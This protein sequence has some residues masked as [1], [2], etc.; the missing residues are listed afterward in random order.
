LWR[1]KFRAAEIL[2]VCGGGAV[3]TSGEVG[4]EQAMEEMLAGFA[5]DGEASGNVGA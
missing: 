3:G 4:V 1:S 5:A 2:L